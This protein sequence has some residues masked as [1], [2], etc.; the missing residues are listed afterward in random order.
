MTR[1]PWIF[2]ALSVS[3]M[4]YV[5]Q[6]VTSRPWRE[7]WLSIGDNQENMVFGE[8]TMARVKIVKPDTVAD[9]AIQEIFHWVTEVEGAV[10]NHFYV[11]MNFPEY[12]KAKLGSNKVLW[13]L[14]ELTLPEIQHVG[15]LVS[16]DNGWPYCTAAFC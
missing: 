5:F 4:H 16:I 2:R 9:P 3:V 13:E 11:E 12:L 8:D 10:P 6:L 14:V 1:L 15:I 7:Q